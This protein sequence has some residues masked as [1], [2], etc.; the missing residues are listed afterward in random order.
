MRVESPYLVI[1]ILNV[2]RL[3]SLIKGH[4]MTKWTELKMTILYA[5]YNKLSSTSRINID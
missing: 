4:R 1:I 5:A 3:N 2:Y